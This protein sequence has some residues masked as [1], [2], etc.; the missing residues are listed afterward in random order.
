MSAPEKSDDKSA[1]KSGFNPWIAVAGIL[2]LFVAGTIFAAV[3]DRLYG[4]RIEISWTKQELFMW[5]CPIVIILWVL[6]GINKKDDGH[7]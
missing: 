6:K 7:H 4:S 3:A 2:I 5:V 1:K